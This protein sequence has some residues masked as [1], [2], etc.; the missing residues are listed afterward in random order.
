MGLQQAHGVYSGQAGWHGRVASR[1]GNR[2]LNQGLSFN[3]LHNL[4]KS[5][6]IYKMEIIIRALSTFTTVDQMRRRV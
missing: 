3:Q 5:K 1:T 4:S 2:N 6:F